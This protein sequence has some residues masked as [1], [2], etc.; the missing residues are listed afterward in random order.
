MNNPIVVFTSQSA[1]YGSLVSLTYEQ[2]A[3][4][5]NYLPV[6]EGENSDLVYFRIY[7]NF[8]SAANIATMNNIS[9]TTYDGVGSGSHTATQS[10]VSQSWVR[11]YETGFGESTV[12]PGAYTQYVDEDTPIG[13]SGVD[14]YFPAYGSD[15]SINPYIRAGSNGSGVGFIE[16]ATY[17]QVPSGA[18]FANY[19]LAISIN[20]YWTT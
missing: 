1:P 9:L 10:P 14:S 12:S 20:Y 7:N 3:I 5:G 15:G 4:G 2:S 8:N 13:R 6:K 17:T 16:F 11:I 19:S 18:G